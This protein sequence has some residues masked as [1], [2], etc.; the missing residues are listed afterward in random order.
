M[1]EN[2]NR[3]CIRIATEGDRETIYRMR[4]AVY[5]TE[6]GQHLPNAEERLTD[7]LDQFNLYIV[8]S[9]GSEIVGFVSITRPD[10]DSFS[11]DK[12]FTR[13]EM[14][15]TWDD[16]LY[17]VRLLTVAGGRRRR[18]IAE[19]LM[20]AVFR[21][22]SEHGGKRII[23]IG[24]R[25]LRDLYQKAGLQMLGLQAKS[26]A[27]TYELM[28]ATISDLRR[29]NSASV[30]SICARFFSSSAISVSVRSMT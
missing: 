23:A 24:R 18:G 9:R 26:G 2:M 20:Y 16:T 4:H 7:A 29:R 15:I 30:S 10:H 19:L 11:V 3:I 21:W 5:A 17:E 28:S 13:E 14:P 25:D 12:Y 27:V 6:L 22:I 8:A 1:Q